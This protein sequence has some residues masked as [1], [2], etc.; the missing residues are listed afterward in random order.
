MV[1]GIAA[2][3]MTSL[4]RFHGWG[5]TLSVWSRGT[6]PTVSVVVPVHESATTLSELVARISAALSMRAAQFEI[7]LVNDGSR[8][9]SWEQI[10]SLGDEFRTLRGID[11]RRNSGQHNAILAGVRAAH[12]DVVVTLDDDLQH[13]PEA[14]GD[15]LDPLQPECDVVYGS[16]RRERHRLWRRFGSRAAKLGV[17]F[18]LGWQGATSVSDF[19][20]FR[21]VPSGWLRRLQRTCC[22]F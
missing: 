4:L 11:L 12:Y 9:D 17:R 1:D 16:P 19:R 13:P 5:G 15:L 14:I 10:E 7:I 6:Q 20:A 3:R 18:A 2:G 22:L 21:D 8:D